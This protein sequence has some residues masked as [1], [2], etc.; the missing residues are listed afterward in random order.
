MNK[1]KQQCLCL[2][3]MMGFWTTEVKLTETLEKVTWHK[4]YSSGL[5]IQCVSFSLYFNTNSKTSHDFV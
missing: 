2:E 1:K 5:V 4:T 3:T